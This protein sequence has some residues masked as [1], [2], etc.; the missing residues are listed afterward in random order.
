[1]NNEESR[2]ILTRK[3]V[4]SLHI[5]L[6]NESKSYLWQLSF[7]ADIFMLHMASQNRCLIKAVLI[8]QDKSSLSKGQVLQVRYILLHIS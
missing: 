5:I 3:P 7:S 2:P 1:M 4:T 6:I 8:N